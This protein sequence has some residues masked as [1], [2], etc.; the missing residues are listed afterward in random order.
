MPLIKSA[1][2]QEKWV[3]ISQKYLPRGGKVFSFKMVCF[4]K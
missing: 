2:G 3:E 4:S 1:N